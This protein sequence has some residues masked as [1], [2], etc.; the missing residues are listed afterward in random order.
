MNEKLQSL[1]KELDRLFDKLLDG[2]FEIMEE[3]KVRVSAKGVT[4]KDG[5]LGFGLEFEMKFS[6]FR[7]FTPEEKEAIKGE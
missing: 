7:D 1:Y 5:E 4:K 2:S 3:P 6:F